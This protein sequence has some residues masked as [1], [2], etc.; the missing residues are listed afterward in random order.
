MY[1]PGLVE[2]VGVGQLYDCNR[3]IADRQVHFVH[4]T[5]LFLHLEFMS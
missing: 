1:Q 2:G 4:R 3:P 5:F